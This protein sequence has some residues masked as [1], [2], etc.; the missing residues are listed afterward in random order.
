[1][2]MPAGAETWLTQDTDMM[3]MPGYAIIKKIKCFMTFITRRLPGQAG[4]SQKQGM[5]QPGS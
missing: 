2:H 5:V 1:M 4:T 3:Q